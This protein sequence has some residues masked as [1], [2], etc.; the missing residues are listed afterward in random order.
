MVT[1]IVTLFEGNYKEENCC[2]VI[3]LYKGNCSFY[4]MTKPQT[5]IIEVGVTNICFAIS[6][7]L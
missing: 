7:L 1:S 5:I 6:F 2:Y 3:Y 4:T